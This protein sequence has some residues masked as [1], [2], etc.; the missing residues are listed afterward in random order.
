MRIMHTD[1]RY[2]SNKRNAINARAMDRDLLEPGDSGGSLASQRLLLSCNDDET[3]QEKCTPYASASSLATPTKKPAAETP[4]PA[5]PSLPAVRE[6][7]Q[8]HVAPVP[9]TSPLER[10]AIAMSRRRAMTRMKASLPYVVLSCLQTAIG[11]LVVGIGGAAF[12][13]TPTF[14][15]GSFWAGLVVRANLVHIR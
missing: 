4:P 9:W 11:A 2:Y 1:I 12:A 6:D 3:D 7:G 13:T 5:S 8:Q 15:A 10:A 14:R